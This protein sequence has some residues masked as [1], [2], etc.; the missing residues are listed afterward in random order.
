[1]SQIKLLHSGGN[2]VILAAPTNNPTSDVTFKLPQADGTS[3]QVLT[4]NASG[5]LAFA[6]V[7]GFTPEADGYRLTTDFS[8]SANPISSNWERNDSTWEGTGYLGSSLITQSSGIWTFAKTGWY[9]FYLQH[10]AQIGGGNSDGFNQFIASISTDSGSNYTNFCENDGWFGD[11]V[12]TKYMVKSSS[13]LIKVANASTYRIKIEQA[14]GSSATT[15]KGS[16]TKLRTG[17]ILL[18]IGDA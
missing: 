4:T 17:F 5:Q 16:S 10:D 12:S 6:T 8:G 9:Y 13:A 3:G 14:A 7:T 1:M 11:N 15:T 18:R 2:G